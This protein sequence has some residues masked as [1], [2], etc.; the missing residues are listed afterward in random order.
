M[1]AHRW[2][3]RYLPGR[4]GLGQLSIP[5]Q[6]PPHAA[7]RPAQP[8]RHTKRPLP[9]LQGFE[10]INYVHTPDGPFLL[11]LCEGNHC[12]GGEEGQDPGH[13]RIIVAEL[14]WKE[15]VGRGRCAAR[16]SCCLSQGQ[17]GQA[18]GPAREAGAAGVM[19]GLRRY[20]G[21]SL[22]RG[23]SASSRCMCRGPVG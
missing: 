3:G 6:G 12:K 2:P 19:P 21:W 16:H 15:W 5:A 20:S 11:G 4:C 8:R 22:Q 13:G 23:A 9:A 14:R 17:G 1:P 7:P 10:S 18:A